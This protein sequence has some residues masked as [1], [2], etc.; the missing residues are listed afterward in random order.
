VSIVLKDIDFNKRKSNNYSENKTNMYNLDEY[1]DIAKKC[2]SMFADKNSAYGMIRNEDAISHV[3]EHVMW[4]H[5]RWKEDGG[6][7]LKSYLNQCAIWA[8]Q[9][10]KTKLYQ[11]SKTNNTVSLN[12][13]ATK[14]ESKELQVQNLISDKKA[15]EPF[16]ILFNDKA[17]EARSIIKSKCLTSLQQKCLYGRYIEGKKLREIAKELNV[18]KQAINQN[19]KK[20]IKKLKEKNELC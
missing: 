10:W 12:S 6:R 16:E 18:S 5:I 7:T 17:F 3:A 2:I 11:K 1:R 9:S 14:D 13:S 15:K 19:I 4:G 8:I 20:A